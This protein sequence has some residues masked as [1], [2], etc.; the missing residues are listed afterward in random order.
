MSEE[1]KKSFGRR[2]FIEPM[3]TQL[4]QGV[5][6]VKLA[7]TCAVG[8][9]LGIFPI[10]GS[11]TILCLIVGFALKMN[12]P[13]LQ[14]VNYVS[15]PAQILLLPVFVRAGERI[16]HAPPVPL[17]PMELVREFGQGV[18]PFLSKYGMAGVHGIT[19][20]A[21]AAPFLITLVYFSLVPAFKALAPKK[22]IS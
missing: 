14:T 2:I 13:A 8:L 20:W 16:F 1:V 5:T 18:G 21:V 4:T 19:A 3:I 22:G 10:L 11:T 12:Q 17:V 6:P 9:A 15:Y 7:S